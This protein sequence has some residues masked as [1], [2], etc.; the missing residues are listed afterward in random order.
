MGETSDQ[1]ERHIQETRNDLGDNFGE[2]E[3]KVKTAV[4]WRAQFDGAGERGKRDDR[5][6]YGLELHDS[7]ILVTTAPPP[8][9]PAE[10]TAST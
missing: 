9:P 1:I 4:D 3:D 6:D 8:A 2:L 5:D 7:S 10:P